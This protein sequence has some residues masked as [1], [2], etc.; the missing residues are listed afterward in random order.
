MGHIAEAKKSRRLSS[1]K[2]SVSS[3]LAQ[4]NEELF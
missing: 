4:E 3:G 2:N 1:W